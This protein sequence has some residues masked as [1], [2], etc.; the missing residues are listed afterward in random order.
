MDLDD[1]VGSSGSTVWNLVGAGG[2]GGGR[3]ARGDRTGGV[4][5]E[6]APAEESR[7]CRGKTVSGGTAKVTSGSDQETDRDVGQRPTAEGTGMVA[8]RRAV[9]RGL[10]RGR[11]CL[12]TWSE[13]SGGHDD[14]LEDEGG[15]LWRK[16]GRRSGG[17]RRVILYP[18]GHLRDRGVFYGACRRNIREGGVPTGGQALTGLLGCRCWAA[19]RLVGR[20]R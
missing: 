5:T 1:V 15:R 19:R 10:R 20:D 14:G 18:S 6:K 17:R 12:V 16:D 2:A 13:S 8:H 9:K 3:V 7:L 11:R 4:A